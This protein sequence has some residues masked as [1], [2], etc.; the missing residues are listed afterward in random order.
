MKLTI[1]L[2][3]S[4]SSSSSS[5]GGERKRRQ[6]RSKDD[7]E[8]VKSQDRG[9]LSSERDGNKRRVSTDRRS[10]S[11]D[12][13]V[14][15][16]KDSRSRSRS[17]SNSVRRKRE[18]SPVIK[19][20]RIHVGRLTRNLKKEHI[21]EIFSSYG[22]I[23]NVEFS[24]DRFHPQNGRGFCYVEFVNPDDAETA[25]KSMDGGHIDGQEVT[26]APVM[27]LNKPGGMRRS[28]MRRG[29]PMRNRGAWGRGGDMRNRRNMRSPDRRA[30]RRSPRRR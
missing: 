16:K 9:R 26:V 18:P 4:S 13:V 22:E 24:T 1:L 25:M 2:F 21:T 17:R 28:P 11:K 27:N 3:S 5:S 10:K 6:S 7:K 12:R 15:R 20:S 29:P 8:R 30:D 14:R 23:R 19:P